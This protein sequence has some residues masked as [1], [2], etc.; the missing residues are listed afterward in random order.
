MV[1]A[2]AIDSRA[3]VVISDEVLV[4]ENMDPRDRQ[5]LAGVGMDDGTFPWIVAERSRRAAAGDVSG[6]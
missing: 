3:E 4:G 1:R 6:R 5:M 2:F